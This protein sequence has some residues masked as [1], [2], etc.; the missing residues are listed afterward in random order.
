M[1][2]FNRAGVKGKDAHKGIGQCSRDVSVGVPSPDDG[3]GVMAMVV[4]V[5][6]IVAA[7]NTG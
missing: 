2:F 6:I 3:G 7:V 5:M 4:M 1:L